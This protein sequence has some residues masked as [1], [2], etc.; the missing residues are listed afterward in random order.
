MND[1]AGP[2]VVSI[3]SRFENIEVVQ[4]VCE[5]VCAKC[6]FDGE[7]TYQVG[8]AL[9]EGVAN[10]MKHGNRFDLSRLVEVRFEQGQGILRIEI[11][12]QGEGF[13][14]SKVPDPLAPENLMKTSGR[15]ILYMK[16][17]MDRYEYRIEP[18]RGTILVIEKR[19]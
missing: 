14:P 13:D 18:G 12:D 8:L 5:N 11:E 1:F 19:I 4:L 17:M 16:T 3:S 9:R 7:K 6:G 10:A 2:V 15:G